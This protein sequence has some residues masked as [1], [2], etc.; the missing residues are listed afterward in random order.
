MPLKSDCNDC[1]VPVSGY[2][3]QLFLGASISDFS[4]QLGWNSSPTQLDITLYED[5]CNSS[6]VGYNEA[7]DRVNWNSADQGFYGHNRYQRID[8][9]YYSAGTKENPADSLTRSAMNLDGL[10]VYFRVGEDVTGGTKVFEYCGLISDWECSRSSNGIAAYKVKVVDPRII[11]QG[12]YLIIGD[13]SGA[14]TDTINGLC[15]PMNVFNVYG[16]TETFGVYSP[17]Y[18]QCS[19]GSYG[20]T[21][22]GCASVDGPV[23]GTYSYGFGGSNSNENG[24]PVNSILQGFNLLANAYP[25]NINAF[26]P[27]GRVCWRQSSIPAGLIGYGFGLMEPSSDGGCYADKDYYFID[28]SELPRF[29][30]NSYRIAG[31]VLSVA[32]L[33]ETMSEDLGFDYYVELVPVQDKANALG[34]SDVAK[35]IKIRVVHRATTPTSLTEIVDFIGAADCVVASSDGRE[36][37]NDT[38]AKFII[39]GNKQTIYQAEQD[40]NPDENYTLPPWGAGVN[41]ASTLADLNSYTNSVITEAGC[42]AIDDIIIPYFGKDRDDNIIV[43]CLDSSG[44]WYFNAPTFEIQPSLQMVNIGNGYLQVGEKELIAA[45]DGFNTWLSYTSAAYTD[46]YAVLNEKFDGI[47]MGDV[48]AVLREGLNPLPRDA[49][50]PKIQKHIK[51]TDSEAEKYNNDEQTIYNFISK[52]AKDYYGKKFAVRV[53]F[54]SSWP[55]PEGSKYRFSD[56]PTNDGGWTEVTPVIGLPNS[57]SLPF[58]NLQPMDF[59]KNEQNKITPFVR[60]DN[61]ILYDI[62]ALDKNDF[63][64]YCTID[65][66]DYGSIETGAGYPSSTPGAVDPKIYFDT[67]NHDIYIYE[68]STTTWHNLLSLCVHSDDDTP[69]VHLAVDT[70]CPIYVDTDSGSVYISNQNADIGGGITLLSDWVETT[71]NLFVRAAVEEEY[72]FHNYLYKFGPRVVVNVGQAVTAVKDQ[73]YYISGIDEI[74]KALVERN[75]GNA[76]TP[77]APAPPASKKFI[78]DPADD[79]DA[80]IANA[81][82]KLTHDVAGSDSWLGFGQQAIMISAAAIPIKSNVLTYGPWFLEGTQARVEV[83]NDPGMVPWQFNGY[84]NLNIAGANRV[85]ASVAQMIRGEHGSITVNGYPSL[86]LGAE[87]GAVAGGYYGGGSY[88][89]E[90]RSYSSTNFSDTDPSGTAVSVDYAYVNYPAWSGIYG[91]NITSISVSADPINGVT[92]QYHMRSF[93]PRQTTMAKWNV[94]KMQ[95]ITTNLVNSIQNIKRKLVNE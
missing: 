23:F 37:R 65:P 6:K 41:D 20:I 48:L 31:T 28:F 72:V 30:D 45:I 46:S 60:Y 69:P 55:D 77:D 25:V 94:E 50:N 58:T 12:V 87:L 75:K 38:T 34:S 81:V 54:T 78:E 7:L 64:F 24:M 76:A 11:L 80:D 27:Y 33:L 56:H 43:P 71:M 10:P 57:I 62:S 79:D 86:P 91:P 17:S 35:F 90:N 63:I 16:Y 42:S 89:V 93:T 73:A 92:T 44:Y 4:I 9:S 88:L 59:F 47:D 18:S 40:Y 83:I 67:A 8:G 74:L 84:A 21:S 5:P 66:S 3:Q 85:L 51:N 52:Y 14:V 49:R 22:V 19:A 29:Y 68:I 36:M 26:S 39:G 61:A 82:E 1:L 15:A 13:Y 95:R 2:K 32:D 53:P 70:F